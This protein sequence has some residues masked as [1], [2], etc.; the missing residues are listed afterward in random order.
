LVFGIKK[1]SNEKQEVKFFF[2]K[3]IYR[4]IKI[5]IIYFLIFLIPLFFIITIGNDIDSSSFG[6]FLIYM[7]IFVFGFICVWIFVFY[8]FCK[9]LYDYIYWLFETKEASE[10]RR[11]WLSFKKFVIDNSEVEKAPLAH[12]KLWGPFYYYT[13]AVGGMKNPTIR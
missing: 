1:M 13:L 8:Q 2:K 12:Y 5:S 7:P 3:F 4:Y 10:N 11:N 6:Q 9:I